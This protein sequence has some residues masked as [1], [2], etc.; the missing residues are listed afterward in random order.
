MS[1]IES[2]MEKHGIP[3]TIKRNGCQEC[4]EIGLE[5]TDSLKRPIICFRPNADV[6]AHDILLNPNGDVFYVTETKMDYEE[7]EPALL[8]VYF[9]SATE[10]EKEEKQEEQSLTLEM[11]M[12]L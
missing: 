8:Q 10:R 6:K 2:F 1:L 12:V 3:Y 5:N 11:L 7:K 4:Q 9:Q